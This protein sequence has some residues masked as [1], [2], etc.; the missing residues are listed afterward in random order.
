MK[1]KK[2][3]YTLVAILLAVVALGIGYATATTLLT[4]NGS[5]TALA[6]D[7]ADLEM[8]SPSA[9]GG[10]TG[11]TATVDSQD[12]SLAQCTVV[13]K[14]AGE[15]ATCTYSVGRAS[16]MDAGV[17]VTNLAASVFDSNNAAWN[18]STDQWFTIATDLNSVTTLSDGDTTTLTITVT[19]KKANLTGADVTETFTVKVDGDV[20]NAS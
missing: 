19:L 13:L 2:R 12:P 5:A 11:T 3:N 14:T 18:N 16:T 9:T 7:G 8:S 10:Q 15:S 4:V 17:D 1:N 20:A 6:S